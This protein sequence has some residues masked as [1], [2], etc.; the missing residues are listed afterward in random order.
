M[1]DALDLIGRRGIV[2]MRWSVPRGTGI[3]ARE[4][5]NK[6]DEKREGMKVRI[7]GR[8]VVVVVLWGEGLQPKLLVLSLE[9]R[10]VHAT[11]RKYFCCLLGERRV[12]AWG[13][14]CVFVVSQMIEE[15]RKTAAEGL[16]E[17]QRLEKRNL[18][19]IK[20]IDEVLMLLGSLSPP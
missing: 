10:H 13:A 12:D 5:G 11:R 18:Q 9:H 16:K 3:I 1:R 15:W 6:M 2:K 20:K 14:R 8:L 7:Q 17:S 19:L 4:E